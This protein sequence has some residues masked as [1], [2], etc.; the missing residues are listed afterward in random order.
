MS[1]LILNGIIYEFDK[2]SSTFFLQI[3]CVL[4]LKKKEK[5]AKIYNKNIRIVRCVAKNYK[6]RF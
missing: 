2:T 3:K 6:R 5:K 1:F 4:K